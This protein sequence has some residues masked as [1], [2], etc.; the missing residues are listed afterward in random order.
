MAHQVPWTKLLVDNFVEL[1]ML[2]T[3]EEFIIRTRVKG[4]TV[5][6]QAIHLNKSESSVHAMIKTMK[7]KYD[8]VQKTYPDIFPE[9]K[10]SAK[11]AYMD[12]H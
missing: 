1:A 7:K 5:T 9:R 4:W 2:S 6:R 10:F 12:T 11:E 8:N 3:D